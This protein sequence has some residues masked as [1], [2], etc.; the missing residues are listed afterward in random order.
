MSHVFFVNLI[1]TKNPIDNTEFNNVSG[2]CSPIYC[3]MP[4]PAAFLFN[5]YG[6]I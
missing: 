6:V 5:L 2:I 3:R 1:L 4:P